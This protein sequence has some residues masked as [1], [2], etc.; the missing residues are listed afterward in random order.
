MHECIN[1]K[2]KF[3]SFLQKFYLHEVVQVSSYPLMQ[4]DVIY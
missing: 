4:A 3:F 2:G 1:G